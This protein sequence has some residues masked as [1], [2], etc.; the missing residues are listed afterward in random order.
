MKIESH[1]YENL[2]G[3]FPGS[4]LVAGALS[5]GG[6][7]LQEKA[8]EKEMKQL[9]QVINGLGED[10]KVMRKMLEKNLEEM[11]QQRSSSS[12]VRED[13]EKVKVD[14]L[15]VFNNI[16]EENTSMTNELKS[17]KDVIYH[18]RMMVEDLKFKVKC[19]C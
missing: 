15:Q 14:L 7:V 8:S 10:N 18:I 13:W 19:C 4:G 17:V 9:Q 5:L 2:V 11:K 6:T 12:E 16:K 1:K 3:G